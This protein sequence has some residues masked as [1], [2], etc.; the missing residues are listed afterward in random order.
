MQIIE[1]AADLR[2]IAED[3]NLPPALLE[4]TEGW[5]WSVWRATGGGDP[6]AFSLS[7]TGPIVI[8]EPDDPP[9][10]VPGGCR[11]VTEWADVV[12]FDGI[13]FFDAGVLAGN[14]RCLRLVGRVGSLHPQVE[15]YLATEALAQD[16]AEG[17]RPRGSAGEGGVPC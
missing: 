16:G 8:L 6:E 5:L 17:D 14:D 4:E 1:T 9:E 11:K 12:E 13:Q 7:A 10:A 15:R 2:R 3:G